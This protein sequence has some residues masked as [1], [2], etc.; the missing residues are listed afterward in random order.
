MV[1]RYRDCD[2]CCNRSGARSLRYGRTELGLHRALLG[3]GAQETLGR[4]LPEPRARSAHPRDAPKAR[5]L[6]REAGPSLARAY[7][8]IRA[9]YSSQTEHETR[10]IIPL[11]P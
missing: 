5:Y 9:W 11:A 8:S 7:E 4:E 2:R 10:L 6:L 3:P 1:Y